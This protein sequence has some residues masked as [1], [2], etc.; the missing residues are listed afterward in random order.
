MEFRD[1]L[2]EEK[3]LC[4]IFGEPVTP[5]HFLSSE[6]CQAVRDVLRRYESKHGDRDPHVLRLRFGFIPLSTEE[7]RAKR[8][9]STGCRSLKEV[10]TYFDVTPE[11]IRQIE[12]RTL[13][14]LRHPAYSSILKT[15]LKTE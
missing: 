14:R 11:R 12:A 8:P 5:A 9:G 7:E 3:L 2:P 10:G 13:R 4:A 1:L 6:G 15:Y